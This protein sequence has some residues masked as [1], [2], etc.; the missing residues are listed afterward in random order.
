MKIKFSHDVFGIF[1]NANQ[2]SF[3]FLFLIVHYFHFFSVKK[4]LENLFKLCK[5]V[6]V[7]VTNFAYTS[8]LCFFFGILH[9]NAHHGFNNKNNDIGCEN[10]VF[11]CVCWWLEV[12][13]SLEVAKCMCWVQY[14]LTK[15]KMERELKHGYEFFRVN[16]HKSYKSGQSLLHYLR[17]MGKSS[18]QRSFFDI[19]S[20]DI[21]KLLQEHGVHHTIDLLSKSALV[22]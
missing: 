17:W 6:M 9:V 21:H 2:L 13:I 7:R 18:S 5:K 10:N 14:H 16:V 8:S 12:C 22:S 1:S 4:K 20:N 15:T 3:H 19:F 11:G